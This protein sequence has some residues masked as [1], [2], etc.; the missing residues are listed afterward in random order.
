M[1]V[2]A[3]IFSVLAIA[4]SLFG[5]NVSATGAT[6]YI[7]L[8]ELEYSTDKVAYQDI[9]EYKSLADFLVDYNSS[10][11]PDIYLTNFSV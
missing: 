9:K 1:K 4:V 5:V 10:N 6:T 3:K 8:E 7:N 2:F 11:L